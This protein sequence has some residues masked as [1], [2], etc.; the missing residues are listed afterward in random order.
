M[1]EQTFTITTRKKLDAIITTTPLSETNIDNYTARKMT[2]KQIVREYRELRQVSGAFVF[3]IV[4]R[5]GRELATNYNDIAYV[6]D[7]G[8]NIDVK[9]RD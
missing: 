3:L 1:N 6:A 8:L 2:P 9:Y 7:F 4:R 5:N